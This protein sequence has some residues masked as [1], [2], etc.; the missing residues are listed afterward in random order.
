MNN[1]NNPMGGNLN[2][3]MDT[4]SRTM[5]TMNRSLAGNMNHNMQRGINTPIDDDLNSIFDQRRRARLDRGH[6]DRDMPQ[7]DNSSG[8][9][10]HMARVR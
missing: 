10:L 3:F 7:Q 6:V 8:K 2:S 5:A 1:S 4:M 9:L